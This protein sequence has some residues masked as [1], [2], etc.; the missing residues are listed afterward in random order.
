MK[1]RIFQHW[2]TSITGLILMLGGVTLYF[3]S[4]RYEFDFSLF[5]LSAIE[6]LG[7]LLLWVKDTILTGIARKITGKIN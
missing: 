4:K 5:E 1:S 3:L 7:F 2:V 6:M